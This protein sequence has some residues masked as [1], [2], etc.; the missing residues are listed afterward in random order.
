METPP[1]SLRDRL[2]YLSRRV[3]YTTSLGA[4]VAVAGSN[5]AIGPLTEAVVH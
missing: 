5:I 4:V 3:S 1:C 2:S